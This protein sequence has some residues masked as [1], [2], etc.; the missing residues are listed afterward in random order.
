[1]ETKDCWETW[2]CPD[3]I[4]EYCPAFK[5]DSVEFGYILAGISCPY[6]NSDS[7]YYRDSQ[8][9]RNADIVL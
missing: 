6:Q 8:S 1:M 4:S 9:D 3:H 7:D 2:E 5:R